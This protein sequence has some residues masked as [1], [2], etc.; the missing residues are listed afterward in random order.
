VQPSLPKLAA[1]KNKNKKQI[2]ESSRD[3]YFRFL[4]FRNSIPPPSTVI[5]NEMMT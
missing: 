3:S 4:D 5:P 2:K 1:R